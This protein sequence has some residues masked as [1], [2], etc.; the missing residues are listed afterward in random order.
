LTRDV[1]DRIAAHALRGL[2]HEAC[3]LFAADKG[4]LEV[5]T[6]V[7]MRNAAESREIYQLDGVEMKAAEEWA[8]EAGISI[9]GVMHS[10]THTTAYPS[11]TD[12]SDAAAF[13]P[14]G[15]WHYI[16]VSLKDA[17]PVMRSYRF[18]DGVIAEEALR[19]APLAV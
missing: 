18:V 19:V 6:F 4:S 15:A 14:F 11:P 7:P 5:H 2:P 3:G 8:D 12:V 17:E 1:H 13:D 16:I 10:H 9:V